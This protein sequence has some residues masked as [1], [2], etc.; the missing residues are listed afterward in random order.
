MTEQIAF[1]LRQSN[2]LTGCVTVKI[3]YSDFQ[4]VTKQVV[5]SYT[6]SDHIL[7]QTAKELFGKLYDRRLLVRL[8]GVRFSHLI[9]GNY[10]I[11]LFD[12]TQQAIQLYQAIDRIKNKY[13]ETKL[14]RSRR[15]FVYLPKISL[16]KIKAMYLNCK[17]NLSFRYGTFSTEELVEH[18][19]AKG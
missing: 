13:G 9:P 11:N 18:A 19:A 7:L 2:K 3:R 4:T 8:I 10:Q 1:E 12:D 6:S 17:T 5:I 14:I 15:R 16:G